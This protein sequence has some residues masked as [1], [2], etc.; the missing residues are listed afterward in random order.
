M[1]V[2]TLDTL[3]NGQDGIV[4]LIDVSNELFY[5]LAALGIRVGK[6]VRMIRRCRSTGPLH[7]RAGTTELMLRPEDARCIQLRVAVIYR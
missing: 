4:L 2:A 3:D 5:R 6:T 7:I 1:S